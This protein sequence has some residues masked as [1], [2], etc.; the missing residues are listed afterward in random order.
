MTNDSGNAASTINSVTTG[1]AARSNGG[2]VIVN[3]TGSI[4][5]T[6]A[7]GVYAKTSSTGTI[8]VTNKGTIQASTTGIYGV[9]ASGAVTINNTGD[10]SNSSTLGA[11]GIYAK[12][13][14]AG[15]ITV[16]STG[17]LN[18]RKSGIYA[19]S[20]DGGTVNVTNNGSVASALYAGIYAGSN[21]GSV[22][23]DR[24]ATSP[25]PRAAALSR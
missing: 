18:T 24:P 22:S 21:T 7:L 11:V 3:T 13:T 19:K 6:T 8:Q 5:S 15:T 25:L 9:A 12:N 1:I 2:N 17:T 14:G 10:V 23:I 4:T 16:N 20:T